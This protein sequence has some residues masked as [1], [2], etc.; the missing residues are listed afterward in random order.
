M[1]NQGHNWVI[2]WVGGDVLV[3]ACQQGLCK[4]LNIKCFEKGGR[5]AT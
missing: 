4:G 2:C 1:L 5:Q 3:E